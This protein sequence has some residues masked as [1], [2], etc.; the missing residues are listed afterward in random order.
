VNKPTRAFTLLELLLAMA[1][2]SIL[3]VLLV[4]VV[5]A[6]LSVWAQG[7]NRIDTFSSARQILDRIADE[8]K[9]ARAT[10]NQIEFSENVTFT[11]GPTF[12]ANTSENIFFV[13]P[14]PNISAGDLCVI[15]YRHNATTH[16]LQRAF[17]DS[18]AAW[19]PSAATRYRMAGYGFTASDWRTIASGV[20][21][22]EIQSYSQ[23]DLDS[24]VS[25]SPTPA[26]TWS[27]VSGIPIMT[28]N[29]PREVRLRIKVFDD[30]TLARLNVLPPGSST[31][32][33]LVNSAARE[34]TA[35]IML[36]PPH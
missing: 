7:R 29:T 20:L 13:A 10:P 23:Q 33:Q 17:K 9:G 3:V 4:N 28:G 35:D 32:N 25:P 6:T 2:T 34:F 36:L 11:E 5:S 18:Q 31:Y 26:D 16:E 27:S 8:I 12:V 19:L 22:F 30:R 24:G 1:I 14:Y 21:E 15:A